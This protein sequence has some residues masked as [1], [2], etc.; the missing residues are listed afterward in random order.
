MFYVNFHS[1]FGDIFHNLK[2]LLHNFTITNGFL[3]KMLF[4]QIV[5]TLKSRSELKN[6]CVETQI[7]IELK[8]Y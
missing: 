8:E 5:K 7:E 3:I 6:N 4:L 1:I 2:F